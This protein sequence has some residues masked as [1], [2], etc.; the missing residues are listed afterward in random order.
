MLADSSCM[1]KESSPQLMGA[2]AG[3]S[4]STGRRSERVSAGPPNVTSALSCSTQRLI[5]NGKIVPI[6]RTQREIT[7][8]II[9]KVQSS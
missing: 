5:I 3:L 4:S 1:Q 7:I 2:S 9:I 6:N 8:T